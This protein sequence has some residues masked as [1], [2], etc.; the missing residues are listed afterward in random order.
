M[1]RN[2]REIDT[3][4]FDLDETLYPPSLALFDQIHE[5]M[6]AFVMAELSLDHDAASA[7]RDE[8][9]H[10][11]GTTLAGLMRQHNMD[12]FPYLHDVH[13]IDLSHVEEE[14]DLTAAI[15][16]LPGRKIIYTN[17]SLS[18]AEQVAKAR[19]IDHLFD[20]M[21]GVEHADFIPKPERAA[22]E[23]I[24]DKA[25]ITPAQ[26]AFFEDTVKNLREPAAMGLATVLV[27][28][29]VDTPDF[30]HLHRDHLLDA[31]SHIHETL[32]QSSA[33]NLL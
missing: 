10:A 2:F 11:Y 32:S 33:E 7:L 27:R 8:Y 24:F 5:K 19:G 25:A 20:A 23:S 29:G 14:P 17:G 12:P 30:V 28:N 3:W 26:T 13:D 31:L 22:F 6:T 21:Y 18:H 15:A 9:Y 1:T 16:A 4:L